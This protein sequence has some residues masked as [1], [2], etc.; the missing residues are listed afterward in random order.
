MYEEALYN[1]DFDRIVN[2]ADVDRTPAVDTVDVGNFYKIDLSERYTVR[3]VAEHANERAAMARV[4]F[5]TGHHAEVYNDVTELVEHGPTGGIV[6]VH[7]AEALGAVQICATLRENGL[8]L[9][10]IGFGTEVSVSRIVAGMKAGA[11]DFIVGQISAETVL[12][13]LVSGNAEAAVLAK[14]NLRR[15]QARAVLAKLSARERQ[16]LDLLAAGLSNK[17]MARDLGISPRTIE[18]HRMKMM[19]KLGASSSADAIRMQIDACA[20]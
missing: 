11:L 14:A 10:V 7:E 5:S 16:V 1:H 3:I 12:P 4:I 19:G 2:Y 6:L 20:P 15:S 9:P 8:W 13:K 17:A 18:I